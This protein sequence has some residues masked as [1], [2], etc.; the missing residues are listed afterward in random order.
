M[1]PQRTRST[2]R[3]SSASACPAASILLRRRSP[4][5]NH[6]AL[7][8]PVARRRWY[9]LTR[10]AADRGLVAERPIRVTLLVDPASDAELSASL[11]AAGIEVLAPADARAA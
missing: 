3:A 6:R 10:G 2:A 8:L 9:K 4:P 7:R 1:R 11:R 5:S